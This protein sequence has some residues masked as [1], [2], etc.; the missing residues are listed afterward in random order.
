[1]RLADTILQLTY[2]AL[3]FAADITPLVFAAASR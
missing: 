3:L 1:M 2:Y